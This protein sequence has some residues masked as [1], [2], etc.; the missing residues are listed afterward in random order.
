MVL[1]VTEILGRLHPAL[2]HL[3]IGI[4][5]IGLLFQWF[6]QR[7]THAVSLSVIKIIFLA[8][9]ACAWISCIT[10]Y[11]LSTS[12]DYESGLV[13][14][15]MWMGIAVALTA[16]LIFRKI[17]LQKTDNWYKALS[18]GLLVLI[19]VTGHL[20]GSLTHGADYIS[21]AF[22]SDS[23]TAYKIHPPIIHVEEARVYADV[24]QPLFQKDCYNCHGSG[25]QKGKLRMDD[26]SWIMKG[27]KDGS[28][29]IP[30]KAPESELM[31]RIIL[32]TDDEHHMPKGKP[33]L[34]ES[35]IALINWWIS[36]GAD[37]HKKVKEF[38]QP[39]RIRGYLLALESSSDHA[40][41]M[42]PSSPV[43]EADR[44]SIN[45]LKEKG[46]EV[47]PVAQN[48]HYLMADFIN[49]VSIRDK[50]LA[51]LVP[52]KKQLIWLKLGNTKIGDSSA[53]YIGQCT[54]LTQLQL[55]RTGI[56]NTGLPSLQSLHKLQSL[57]L[58]GTAVT[59]QGVLSLKA[60]KQLKHLY[61]YQTGV[62]DKDWK[63]LAGNFPKT[64]IDSGGYTVS[65][66]AADT[67][68]VKAG[69]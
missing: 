34:K 16:S 25:R 22:K 59:A 47:I 5:L 37:F 17:I 66:I 44:K 61:L 57:N 29:L 21:S 30:F 48:S 49:S 19:T 31:K 65:F 9:T 56:S 62:V 2:V 18:V 4:L 41:S 8:G 38:E 10:G 51:L 50:D 7:G 33:S 14:W 32:P 13:N 23:G 64:Q 40:D 60:L 35:Q 1:S 45:A 24:I 3:P 58:V 11:I 20:G 6:Y 52:L 39:T 27:G 67:V 42:V 46:V 15:H 68:V 55:D 54:E 63:M 36:T 69:K 43:E 26:S 28:I 53:I 12:G